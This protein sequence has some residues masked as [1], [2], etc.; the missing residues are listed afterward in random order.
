MDS[1]DDDIPDLV[2]VSA[3]PSAQAQA[4]A[5]ALPLIGA[6]TTVPPDNENIIKV[7][8]TIVTGYLGA[9]KSSLLNNIM[10]QT[11]KKIAVIMNEF[12]D[13][14][15]I[16]KSLTV[17]DGADKY[18]EWL[19]LGN[20]CL[21]CS[22]KDTG[23]AALESL[24][25]KKGKFDYILLETTG[26]ADPGPIAQMFWLDSAL[27]STVYLDGI[28]T[29]VDAANIVKSLDDVF[30]DDHHS[31]DVAASAPAVITTSTAQIQLSYAD[32]VILNKS[33]LLLDDDARETVI[34]RLAGINSLAPII[35][36]VYANLDSLDLIL[37][38]NTVSADNIAKWEAVDTSSRHH[39]Y[40]DH[41]I[42]TITITLPR[43]SDEQNSHLDKWLQ[44]LLW[45]DSLGDEV[46][47]HRE[48]QVH[49]LKGKILLDSGEVFVIQAVRDT[50][51]VIP[52]T[53]AAT[54]DSTD[55][56][57]M[58]LI[59][60]GLHYDTVRESLSRALKCKL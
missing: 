38:L 17:S 60:K 45:E 39:S 46:T 43:L 44:N 50:Y 52:I 53:S 5:Q 12:G 6:T 55:N 16:E 42:S 59:G 10:R 1:D 40:H 36:T 20:G 4:Q 37:D 47:V 56:G 27:A 49:R 22:V 24:M 15:D 29:V 41:R 57:K 33:D 35:P 34:E 2:D 19:E 3:L 13:S 31:T 25:E 30:L 32:V 14:V 26:L 23:V 11:D 51:D 58:V 48:L 54:G 28:V 18:T 8:L 21:C 7:P 9:G